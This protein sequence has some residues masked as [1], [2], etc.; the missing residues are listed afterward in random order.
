[1]VRKYCIQLRY[2]SKIKRQVFAKMKNSENTVTWFKYHSNFRSL[3]G[4]S[5]KNSGWEKPC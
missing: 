3:E 5:I 2:L 1:M 4:K